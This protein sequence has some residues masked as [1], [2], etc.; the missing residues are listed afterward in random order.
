[1]GTTSAPSTLDPAAAWDSSWELFRNVFQTLLNY[2]PGASEPEPD[3]AESCRFTDTSTTVYSCT[4]REGLKFSDGRDLDAQAVK[5]S[6]D[7]VKKIKVNGGP[8]GLLGSLSRVQVK[9]DREVVFH[10]NEPD[11]TFPFVLSTPAMSIVNPDEY[12]A[13]KLREDGKIGGSGPYSLSSYEDGERAELVSNDNYNG[14]ADR[15]NNGVTIRYFKQSSDMVDA[16]KD[17]QIDVIYR[18]LPAS[19]TVDIQ[20]KGKDEGSSS[21]RTPR[22]RSVTWCST[23]RTH[24][25][26]G[27]RSARR[28]PR[29]STDRCSPTRSTRTPS[30]R[31]TP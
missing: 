14:I 22:P 19:E 26:R 25:P 23:P 8:V 4:L 29:S 1:M 31:C 30:N 20:V 3:A 15:K 24:G 21:S 27:P 10:L 12:A 2:S 6:I 7:R 17:K 9:G 18:G 11:A 13:D 5:Y 16:L 28:S